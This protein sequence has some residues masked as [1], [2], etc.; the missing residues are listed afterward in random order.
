MVHLIKAAGS[1]NQGPTGHWR[2]EIIGFHANLLSRYSP[3]MRERIDMA[4][5]WRQAVRQAEA[6]LDDHGETMDERLK[7]VCLFRLED[8]LDGQIDASELIARARRAGPA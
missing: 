1:S 8:F 7:V 6:A 5:I 3:S 4:A 2:A